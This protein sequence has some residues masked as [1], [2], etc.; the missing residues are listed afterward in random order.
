[1]I[2][3]WSKRTQEILF[4]HHKNNEKKNKIKIFYKLIKLCFSQ[5]IKIHNHKIK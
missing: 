5:I 1:M 2:F 4:V 3:L